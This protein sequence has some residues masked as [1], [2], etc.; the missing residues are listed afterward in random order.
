MAVSNILGSNLLDLTSS[1]LP[2]MLKTCFLVPGSIVY[3]GTSSI[4][5]TLA[6][7]LT[8][9]ILVVLGFTLA[10]W[11]LTKRVGYCYCVMYFVY[12]AICC[13]YELNYFG[14][15]NLPMCGDDTT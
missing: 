6:S 3:V 7:L 2:W 12:V 14:L 9:S 15:I 13:L 10:G 11:K 4:I 8:S 5:F 1:G